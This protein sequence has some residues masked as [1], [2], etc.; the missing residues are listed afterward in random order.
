[1]TTLFGGLNLIF[2]LLGIALLVLWAF[3]PFAI[4]GQKRRLDALI[5]EQR[6]TNAI[7]SAMAAHRG[8]DTSA[9]APLSADENASLIDVFREARS[10]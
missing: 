1:M 5:G 4:F 10:K 9:L 3:V 7:L 8:I 6:R 2:I